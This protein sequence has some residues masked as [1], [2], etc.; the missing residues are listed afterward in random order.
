VRRALA[1]ATSPGALL[2]EA[3]PRACEVAPDSLTGEDSAPLEAYLKRLIAALREL[4]QAYPA[5]REGIQRELGQRLLGVVPDDLAALRRAVVRRYQG[6]DDLT[7]DKH[8]L[9]AFIRRLGSERAAFE[10]SQDKKDQV[11]LESVATLLAGA[12]PK[13]WRDETWDAARLRLGERA[14]QLRE[15]ERLRSRKRLDQ[16]SDAQRQQAREQ[17]ADIGK[18]LLE[19]DPA[20]RQAV[21]DALIEQ[22][23]SACNSLKI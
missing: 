6:L 21:L 16:L 14:T 7:D 18:R 15:L 5:L 1:Q 17:A 11:W 4:N 22:L 10:Q 23:A 19:R 2:F 8:G 12:P 20:E 3:L 13:A 9:G